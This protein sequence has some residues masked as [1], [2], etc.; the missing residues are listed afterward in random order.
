MA[1]R[2]PFI[3]AGKPTAQGG[4][5]HWREFPGLLF[6]FGDFADSWLQA[7]QLQEVLLVSDRRDSSRDQEAQTHGKAGE[8]AAHVASIGKTT[9]Q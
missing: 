4:L 1:P 9:I 8:R 3:S 5:G 2:L 6:L 7:K